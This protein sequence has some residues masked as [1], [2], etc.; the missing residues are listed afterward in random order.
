MVSRYHR[1][2]HGD[3]VS[4]IDE[5]GD[6]LRKQAVLDLARGAKRNRTDA[7]TAKDANRSLDGTI[8]LDD[9]ASR[10]LSSEDVEST[11]DRVH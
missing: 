5:H 11:L 10:P 6:P 4:R 8:H 7:V 3:G 9:E 2:V 1:P